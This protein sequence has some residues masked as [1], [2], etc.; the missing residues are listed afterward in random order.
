MLYLQDKAFSFDQIKTIPDEEI[1]LF[2]QEQVRSTLRFCK[3]WLNGETSFVF[4]TSGSTGAPKAIPITRKQMELSAKATIKALAL[5]QHEHI[6]V[7]LHTSVI[8]GAMMLVRGFMLQA[9]ITVAEPSSD[10]LNAIPENHPYT[11]VSFVPLQLGAL[12]N[13]HHQAGDKLKRFKHILLG[14]A[15]VHQSLHEKLN[16]MSAPVW[17]TYGMTETVSHIALR[18]LTDRYF[19]ALP[20]IQLQ[21]DS[22]GCLCINGSVTNYQWIVTNDM[23]H[24]RDEH[25]FE[26]LGRADDVIN[27]GGLKFFTSQ[28]EEAIQSVWSESVFFVAGIPHPAL[29]EQITAIFETTAPTE[30]KQLEIKDYITRHISP[31]AVP[32]QYLTLKN[33]VRTPSGKINKGASLRLLLN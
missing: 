21:T 2:A 33:L 1:G 17:Y 9:D 10:P 13:N 12:L 8:G 24:F 26:V 22:R 29:G 18:K 16:A 30:K 11:F 5:N 27:S 23:V 3:Q 31:Y 28:I 6:Y 15:P 20:D 14:G 32:R 25:T 19:T 7:C 4:H